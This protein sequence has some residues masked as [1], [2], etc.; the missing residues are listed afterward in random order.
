MTDAPGGPALTQV[1]IQAKA[2]TRRAPAE[3]VQSV[4]EATLERQR[5]AIL[6]ER[7][8]SGL[9]V[10][11]YGSLLWERPLACD[12][13][14]VGR[15]SGMIR[16]SCLWDER[17]RGTPEQR[18]LTLGI[19]PGSGACSGAVLH[20]P[21]QGLDEALR[22]VWQHEMACGFYEPRWVSVATQAGP[23]RAVTF[24]A[25]A[26]Q[27]HYAG[28]MPPERVADI[29]AG[30]AGLNGSAAEYLLNTAEWLRAHGNPDAG[31]DRLSGMVAERLA[32]RTGPDDAA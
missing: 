6:A 24:V 10:F 22:A 2:P 31:L 3:P 26:Q 27:P 20:L 17:D 1:L 9:W 14:R 25:D 23:V 29:L 5:R 21:K 16:R 13:E 30:T 32:A 4:P 7:N 11:A 12:A 15:V 8:G 19:E 18:S 28:A